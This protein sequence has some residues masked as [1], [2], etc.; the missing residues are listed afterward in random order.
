MTEPSAQPGSRLIE[1]C[2]KFLPVEGADTEEGLYDKRRAK[3]PY[4]S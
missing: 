3:L 2:H 4:T 1:G